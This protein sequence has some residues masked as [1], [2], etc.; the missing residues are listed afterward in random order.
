MKESKIV[1]T[2]EKFMTVEEVIAR[3]EELGKVQF[4]NITFCSMKETVDGRMIFKKASVE[5]PVSV[6]QRNCKDYK[7]PTYH[8]NED[9]TYIVDNAIKFNNTTKNLLLKIKPIWKT[10]K[11]EYYD[12]NGNHIEKETAINLLKPS[13]HFSTDLPQVLTAKATQIIAIN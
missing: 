8:R 9:S 10:Y 13:K 11:S 7:E 5:V 3:M 4:H 2:L 1:E 12:E 6:D